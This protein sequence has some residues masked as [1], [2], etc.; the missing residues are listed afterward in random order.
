MLKFHF[1]LLT[2]ALNLELGLQVKNRPRVSSFYGRAA[3][4]MPFIF[5]MSESFREP[6]D[7]LGVCERE[8]NP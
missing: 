1:F 2:H 7:H 5:I 3:P 8:I 6:A 4:G